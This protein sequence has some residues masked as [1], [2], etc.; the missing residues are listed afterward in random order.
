MVGRTNAD[1]TGRI[2]LESSNSELYGYQALVGLGAGSFAQ[3]GFA[4]IQATV[5]PK[6]GVHVV[7]LIMLGQLFGLAAGLSVTGALF[8]N[9]AKK[10]LQA[11]FPS[12]D[13]STLISIV[14]GT[15]GGFLATQSHAQQNQALIAIVNALQNVFTEVYAVAALAFVL[16]VFLKVTSYYHRL[17]KN[18]LLVSG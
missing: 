13:E 8:I 14:S 10:N 9:L 2:K 11:V 17:T 7:T 6:D 4:V 3:A 12:V 16:S 1:D 18:P 5:N 15:S